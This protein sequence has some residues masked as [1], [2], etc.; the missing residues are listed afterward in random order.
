MTLEHTEP[1]QIL[2]GDCRELLKT[3][4]ENY[5]DLIVTSPPYADARR[6]QYGGVPPD[7]YGSWFLPIALEFY[8][9][10]KP[11]GTWILNI[12]EKC[13]HRERSCYVI[14]LILLLR[15]LGWLWTEEFIWHKKTSVPGKWSTRFRD[16]W[17]RLLQFNKSGSFKMYQDAVMIPCQPCTKRRVAKLSPHS[18]EKSISATGQHAVASQFASRSINRLPLFGLSLPATNGS[19]LHRRAVARNAMQRHVAVR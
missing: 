13:V 17:E 5:V 3:L 1:I 4:P 6:K 16:A 12:K 18:G 19:G 2:E 8:R 7:E 15:E 14:E 9:V 10:L 11:D